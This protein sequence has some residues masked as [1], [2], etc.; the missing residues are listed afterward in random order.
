MLQRASERIAPARASS[1]TSPACAS[2]SSSVTAPVVGPGGGAVAGVY[3]GGGGAG[4]AA[5]TGSVIP[6]AAAK[7]FGAA[8]SA[9]RHARPKKA[10]RFDVGG[11]LTEL[12]Y[13][14]GRPTRA[15]ALSIAVERRD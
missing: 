3:S 10:L 9:S 15:A 8:A 2:R 7:G 13:R 6:P 11:S 4:G 5:G 12:R 14:A 1:P